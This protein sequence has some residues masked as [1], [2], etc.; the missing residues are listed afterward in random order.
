M[1]KEIFAKLIVDLKAVDEG[2]KE[3]L[4]AR[5]ALRVAVDK[6]Q[7]EAFEVTKIELK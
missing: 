7:R 6:L 4:E 2:I 3:V 5:D 1:E